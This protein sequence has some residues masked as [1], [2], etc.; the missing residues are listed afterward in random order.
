MWKMK[1]TI[2]KIVIILMMMIIDNSYLI[3]NIIWKSSGGTAIIACK[4]PIN[5]F[6]SVPLPRH[7]YFKVSCVSGNATFKLE[8]NIH[9]SKT[10]IQ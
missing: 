1:I 10:V 2:M 3:F 7:I 5:L 6:S 9:L 4:T 8:S